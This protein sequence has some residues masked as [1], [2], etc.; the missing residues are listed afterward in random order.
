MLDVS[1]MSRGHF[2][3]NGHDLGK[4]CHPVK[5]PSRSASAWL[6]ARARV[7]SHCNSTN[8]N[9][10]H[11]APTDPPGARALQL[12]G[13]HVGFCAPSVKKFWTVGGTQ[14]YYQLPRS[15]LRADPTV[16]LLVLA[17]EL[18]ATDPSGVRV[19][20]STMQRCDG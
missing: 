18:G 20:L 11:A 5:Q 3:L 12:H 2:Y 17:D 15:L 10:Q 16:N 19:V 14:R 1:G 7:Q 4:V 6:H 9:P 13:S 8:P